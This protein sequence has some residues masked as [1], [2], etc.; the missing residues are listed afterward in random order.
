MKDFFRTVSDASCAL[1]TID[2]VYCEF[3]KYAQNKQEYKDAL[4]FL[5]SFVPASVFPTKE[6]LYASNQIY[7]ALKSKDTNLANRVSLE[8]LLLGAMLLKWRKEMYLAT[9]NHH[10]FPNWLYTREY[11]HGFE[12]QKG[13]VHAIGVY[14]LDIEK[15]QNLIAKFV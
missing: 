10:D 8:D 6:D 15:Y 4:E 12:D 7:L 1:M 11:L 9:I 3:L 13:N 2:Q 14:S 5:L